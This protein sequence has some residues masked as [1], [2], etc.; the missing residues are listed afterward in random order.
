MDRH[1]AKGD[2]QAKAMQEFVGIRQD[3]SEST[4]AVRYI[5]SLRRGDRWER[6]KVK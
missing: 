6:L 4:D 3:R 2:G 1:L 5:R